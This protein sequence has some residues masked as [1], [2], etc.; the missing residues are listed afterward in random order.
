[1]YLCVCVC[2]CVHQ[3]ATICAD[4]NSYCLCVSCV[5]CIWGKISLP[6]DRHWSCLKLLEL[7]LP[8]STC[9]N[10]P[11]TV[12]APCL[13][14]WFQSLLVFDLVDVS[15]EKKKKRK[16]S[17]WCIPF[18][19]FSISPKRSTLFCILLTENLKKKLKRGTMTC[20]SSEWFLYA[21]FCR[22]GQSSCSLIFFICRCWL[23]EFNGVFDC[24]PSKYV[25]LGRWGSGWGKQAILPHLCC[26]QGP[27]GLWIHDGFERII[28]QA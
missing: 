20:P 26:L 8:W 2:V 5:L 21:T 23:F 27:Y 28:T 11:L 4:S 15:G 25:L 17:K 14:L 7:P 1:M 19:L 18:A 22:T 3:L 16:N 13:T 24:C 10:R 9:N 12:N 6:D